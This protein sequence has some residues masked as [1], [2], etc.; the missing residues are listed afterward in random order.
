MEGERAWMVDASYDVAGIVLTFVRTDDLQ[1]TR[2]SDPSFRPY[3]LVEEEQSKDAVRKLDIFKESERVLARVE[4]AKGPPKK[5]KGWETDISPTQSYVYDNGLR[6]GVIH[7]FR[8]NRWTPEVKLTEQD[9]ARFKNLV[10]AIRKK[11]L[12]KLSILTQ[13]YNFAVQPV[14]EVGPETLG[15]PEEGW[16]EEEYHKAMLL[17]RLTN[18]P[19]RVTYRK[20]AVSEWIRSMLHNYYRAHDILVPNSEEMRLGS[21]KKYV[22]GALTI[23]PA[24]GTYFGMVVLDFESLY[25]GVADVYNLS[26]ETIKCPHEECRDNLV[27]GLD[28]HVCRKRRGIYS[29]IL[30]ALRELRVHHFKLMSKTLPKD[31]ADWRIAQGASQALKLLL[32]ASYGVTVRIHGLASPLLGEA[33]TAYGRHVLQTSFD[34]AR[35]KG[36][37]PKY[38]DTDSL[39]LD[40]P[41][42]DL[43]LEFIEHIKDKLDLELAHDRKYDVCVL[44]NAMKAYFGI[45]PNGEPEIKGL[46]V[47]K[48]NSPRFFLN[49]F[50]DCLKILS[51]GRGSLGEW[52]QAKKQIQSVVSQSLDRLRKGRVPIED[53]TYKV[54]LR[55]DP[56]EKSRAR[57]IP[58]AYQAAILLIER[59]GRLDRRAEVEFVKVH[60]FKHQ[61]RNFTV[62]PVSDAKVGELNVDDYVRNLTSSLQQT[63]EPMGIKLR[64]KMETELQDF[65]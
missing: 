6:F 8:D 44:S 20:F 38:G 19:I 2:W 35:E 13:T 17:S 43:V 11:D 36:L 28:Y 54:E 47:A 12:L 30:G 10:G 33:I 14:P 16:S 26:Y 49:T 5:A 7:E 65:S 24:S 31:S 53:L 15:L 9:T 18:L 45:L 61:G 27:P 46:T 21:D 22:T 52:E 63:F 51:N 39:F 41:Q 25:A 1:P 57:T 50:Q 56:L 60:P 62:K 29:A 64:P 48:S 59:G 37:R 40:N 42:E 23:A 34:M 58:Q 32:N 3:Y 4:Y 55:D